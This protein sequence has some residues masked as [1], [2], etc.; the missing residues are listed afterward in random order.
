MLD[1][2]SF[3]TLSFFK[4]ALLLAGLLLLGIGCANR[5]EQPPLEEATATPAAASAETAVSTPLPVR[6]TTILADG[7]LVAVYPKVEVSFVVNGRL[8]SL[9]VSPGDEVTEGDVIAQL[10]DATLQE[11]VVE[12]RLAVTQ[13]ETDLAQAQ[14]SL[15][16]LV[17]WEP[18]AAAVALAEA[19]LTAAQ[20]DLESANTQ[21]SVAGNSITSARIRLEQAQRG[22]ADAQTAYDT[23]FDPGREWELH[24]NERT[25]LVGQGGAIPCTGETF[26]KLMEREREGAT[27]G[28]QGAKDNLTVAQADYN[29]AVAQVNNNRG[30]SA[31]AAVANAQQSLTAAN[32]G[33]KASEIEAARLT[34]DKAELAVEQT[35]LN[36]AKAE[37][38]VAD[39]QLTAP[40]A[41]TVLAVNV[42]PGALINAGMPV[43]V[44]QNTAVLQFQTSNLSERDLAQVTPGQSVA[45]TLKTFPN[46]PLTGTVARIVPEASGAVGDAATFTAVIDLDPTDLT[47][48]P[49]MTGRVE[50]RR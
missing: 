50:I 9:N 25:C 6:G 49:G 16:N 4:T 37:K 1:R 20:A 23:A 29:L 47:L 14:L 39:A 17:N 3:N 28:L 8:L 34:L 32:T 2:Y 42:A 26:S 36:L 43:V 46:D 35:K 48:L 31:E 44:V 11:S 21:D 24:Y 40:I 45:L 30:L 5:G 22:L 18:D 15:D 13:A 19:N 10:D 38:A 27:R 33:P 7:R 41:G 12:A